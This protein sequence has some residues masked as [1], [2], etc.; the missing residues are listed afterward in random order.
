MESGIP[1]SRLRSD[2]LTDGE[3]RRLGHA[4]GL[5]CEARLYPY[6]VD[7]STAEH[8]SEMVRGINEQEP[9]DLVVIDDQHV[10]CLSDLSDDPIE[11]TEDVSRRLKMLARELNVSFV[12]TFQLPGGINRPDP[13]M[14]DLRLLGRETAIDEYADAVIL[15]HRDDYYNKNSERQGVAELNLAKHSSGPTGQISVLFSQRTAKFLD[16]GITFKEEA[17]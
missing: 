2:D 11:A 3:S 7:E 15:I 1:T 6:A 4:L 16:L 13:R 9:L 12:V 14:P 5:L 10:I 8:F 17:V